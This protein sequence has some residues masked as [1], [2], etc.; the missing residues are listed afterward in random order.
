MCIRDR[1]E[2]AYK[3]PDDMLAGY[4]ENFSTLSTSLNNLSGIPVSYTHLV[5][6]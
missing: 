6:H 2:D 4:N 3:V 1:Y 5:K